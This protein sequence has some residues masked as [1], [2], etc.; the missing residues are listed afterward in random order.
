MI[1][2]DWPVQDRRWMR[3]ALREAACA[4]GATAPNP[5]VGCVIVA[6]DELLGAGH[7]RV[8]GGPHGEVAAL[9]D[10]AARG[11]DPAGATAYVTLA[12]C[13]RHGRTPPC[14]DALIA[15][16]VARVVAALADPVQDLAGK[17]LAAAGIAYD[18]GCEAAAAVAM[19]GGFLSRVTRRRPRVTGK[20]ALTLDGF[21]ACAD[22]HSAWITSA[23]ARAYSRRRRQRF[24]A[25][26]VGG[27]TVAAD[28]PQLLSS[29]PHDR[30]PLRVVVS[31]AA[32]VAL[33]SRLLAS[34]E[35]AP[36][37]VVHGQEADVRALSAA[38]VDCVAMA[39][40]HDV[41]ALLAVL[42]ERGV[43][44]LLVEGGAIV[45]GAFL[46]AGA[47][48]RL[49]VYQGG[50]TLGAGRAAAIGPG[51]ARVDLG[52]AWQPESAPRLLA[53]TVYSTWR[54]TDQDEVCG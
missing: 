4:L 2:A 23:P 11:H 28:D 35:Q 54:R 25:I 3:R 10:C 32:A 42:A 51:V 9:A 6:D 12:P 17:R 50:R 34:L 1:A 21:I 19:H 45:H 8:C 18:V 49:E 47:Y 7:H 5:G 24:D 36:L 43:N 13:T 16:K 29:R 14:V 20:L 44:D 46:A 27:A 38:G 40:P 41:M 15:A 37:L 26:L 31:A 22:G 30:S 33:S 39:D 52:A 53:D 48:D